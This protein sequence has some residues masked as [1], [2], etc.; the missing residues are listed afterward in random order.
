MAMLGNLVPCVVAS[1]LKYLQ[2]LLAT[3]SDRC[4]ETL[5]V[6]ATTQSGIKY[7]QSSPGTKCFLQAQGKLLPEPGQL[8]TP[9][10]GAC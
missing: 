9:C 3:S 7:E 6:S 5:L 2:Y 1:C 4:L 8:L 10:Q